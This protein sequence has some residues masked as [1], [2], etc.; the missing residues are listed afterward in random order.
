LCVTVKEAQEAVVWLRN[1][2]E[3]PDE[4][5]FDII[6]NLDTAIQVYTSKNVKQKQIN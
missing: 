6:M 5:D 3:Q 4:A 1:F 2:F